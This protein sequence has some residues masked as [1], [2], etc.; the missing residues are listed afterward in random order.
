MAQLP[1]IDPT[2]KLQQRWK[3]V[4]DP[5]LAKELTQGNLL[6][7]ISLLSGDNILSHRLGR[8]MTGWFVVDQNAGVTLYRSAAL[9]DKTLTLNASAPVTVSLWV[10]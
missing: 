9:N 6:Q 5:L 7:N 4:L 3:S 10:F 1:L 8:M 2:D